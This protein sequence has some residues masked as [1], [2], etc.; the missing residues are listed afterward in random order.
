MAQIHCYV[1]DD[2]AAR[3]QAKARA[4]HM[5]VSK[6]LAHLVKKELDNQWP[7]DFL[8]TFGGWQGESLQRPDQGDYENRR[9][10]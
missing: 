5:S 7:E 3:L 1:P 10:L 6:Y 2:L 4:S 9:E 8:A